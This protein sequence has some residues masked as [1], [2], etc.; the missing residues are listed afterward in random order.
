MREQQDA[1][2]AFIAGALEDDDLEQRAAFDV[3]PADRRIDR[4]VY[5]VVQTIRRDRGDV[6]TPQVDDCRFR[7]DDALTP[8]I[9]AALEA[10]AQHVMLTGQRAQGLAEHQRIRLAGH[11]QHDVLAVPRWIVERAFQKVQLRRRH[12]H[13]AGHRTLLA[14]DLVGRPRDA[15]QFAHGRVIENLLRR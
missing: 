14:G 13:V 1:R 4:G 5:G 6:L 12:R 11:L 10:A 2:A 3:E 9:C 7:F 8:A 15:G